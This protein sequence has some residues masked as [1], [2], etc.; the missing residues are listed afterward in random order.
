MTIFFPSEPFKPRR[1][2]PDFHSEAEAASAAGFDVCLYDHE[3]LMAGAGPLATGVEP[4]GDTRSLLRGWMM[5]GETYGLL[6]AAISGRG[7]VPVTSPE[8]YEEAHYLPLAYP[9]LEGLTARSV[10]MEG[11]DPVR[12]WELHGALGGGDALL[13]DWVKSAKHKWR[14]ACFLP[15]GVGRER[16][17]EIFACF[18]RERGAL[19]NRGVVIREF[20]PFASRGT[21]LRGMPETEET[22]LF[23]WRGRAL[24]AP[25]NVVE[26]CGDLARWEA[27]A[28][29]FAS[30]FISIDVAPVA[31]GEW[32][33][34]E[35]GDG[36]VSGL[37][38]GL[39]AEAFYGALAERS[40]Q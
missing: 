29:R 30:P 21:D 16:F 31:S 10:W 36:G 25:E 40:R 32:R 23:F 17:E 35:V 1:P 33:I 11:D 3:A 8:A 38:A 6:H 2:D 34:V 26:A 22:R 39:S 20:L 12:A 24:V 28:S 18:R 5:P 4:G 14:E 19:F 37:P 7:A 9:H 27:V 15:A 13:K